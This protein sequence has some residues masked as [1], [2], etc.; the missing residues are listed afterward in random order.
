MNS[1][2]KKRAPLGADTADEGLDLADLVNRQ[3]R[4]VKISLRA[5]DEHDLDAVA[6]FLQAPV[7]LLPVDLAVDK[8]N[9]T[10]LNAEIHERTVAR[11]TVYSDDLL[12]GIIRLAGNCEHHVVRTQKTVERDRYSVR[13]V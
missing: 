10:V 6:E 11:L 12:E 5:L 2:Q 4:S 13:S 9:L 3:G 1:K 8:G 7:S